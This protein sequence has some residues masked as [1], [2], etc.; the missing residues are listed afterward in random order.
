MS[1]CRLDLC[2]SRIL[3]AA[4][5]LSA[6]GTHIYEQRRGWLYIRITYNGK[7]CCN[8][9]DSYQKF[10]SAMI[11]RMAGEP[12]KG[13]LAQIV[14]LIYK[15]IGWAPDPPEEFDGYFLEEVDRAGFG[16]VEITAVGP[17]RD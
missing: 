15:R 12:K 10:L 2:E 13:A 7:L 9:C 11:D 3:I 14:D 16:I 6:G 1:L 17:E 8:T 4:V 5:T